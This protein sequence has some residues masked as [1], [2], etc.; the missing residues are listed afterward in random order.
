M[1]APLGTSA[2][3]VVLRSGMVVDEHIAP[4][5]DAAGHHRALTDNGEPGVQARRLGAVRRAVVAIADDRFLFHHHPLV[6]D[7]T[8]DHRARADHGIGENDRV[9][10][11]GA[12]LH[13]DARRDDRAHD[14]PFDPAAVAK[15]VAFDAARSRPGTPRPVPRSSCGSPS[16]RRRGRARASRPAAPCWPRSRPESCRRPPSSRRSGSR[17]PCAS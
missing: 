8:V 3:V 14:R 6:E 16:F 11:F 2:S 12:C 17:T 5:L 15:Q 9:A 10:Y 4:K 7:G 1:L 13:V